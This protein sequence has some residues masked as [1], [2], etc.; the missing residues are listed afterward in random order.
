M[1]RAPPAQ[2]PRGDSPIELCA[3][4]SWGSRIFACRRGGGVNRGPKIRGGV[5]ENSSI[6]RTIHQL[7]LSEGAA[8][9]FLSIENCQV[10][11]CTKYVANDDFF[12][13]L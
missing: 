3:G 2:C 7:L 13:Y 12:E 8:N 11:V 5:W 4:R 10:F 1:G 6:D 9:I